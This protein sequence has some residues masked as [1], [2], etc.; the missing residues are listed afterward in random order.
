MGR[1]GERGGG[2]T[3]K[4]CKSKQAHLI[5][6]FGTHSRAPS[7]AVT[8]MAE[9]GHVIVGIDEGACLVEHRVRQLGGYTCGSL[10]ALAQ[11][12]R[13]CT[14]GFMLQDFSVVLRVEVVGVEGQGSRVEE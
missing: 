6:A 10:Y 3:S 8:G 13:R 14:S 9:Q 5:P 2:G 12:L 11:L 4:A 7:H 1:E